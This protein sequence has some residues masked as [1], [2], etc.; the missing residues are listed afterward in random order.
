M[1]RTFA[2]DIITP[3]EN[4]LTALRN[5]D[6]KSSKSNYLMKKRNSLLN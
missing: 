1:Q 2:P 6:I 3:K 5:G 4:L